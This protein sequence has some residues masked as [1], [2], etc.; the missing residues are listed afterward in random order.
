MRT[1]IL[2]LC[3]VCTLLALCLQ[4]VFFKYSASSIIYRQG[5]EA[6]LNSLENMQNELYVW[7]KSYENN[8]IKIY[9]E[10]D[11]VHDLDSSMTIVSLQPKYRRMAYDMAMTTFDPSQGVDAL[12]L[13]DMNNHLISYYGSAYTPRFNYP[14]DIFVDPGA[15][16][17]DVVSQ[18]VHSDNKVMLV[19]SYYNT[20][21]SED[22]IRF[23]LKIYSNNGTKKIGYMVCDADI[24]SFSRI[25]EKY[26]YSDSQIVWLQPKGDRPVLCYG[27]PLDGQASYYNTAASKIQKNTWTD[28]SGKSMQGNIFFE[29]PQEKYNLV[30]FSLTPP[31]MQKESERVLQ[32]NTLIIALIVI[33]VASVSTLLVTRSLTT[34]LTNIECTLTKIRNGQTEL[35]LT[36]L[37]PDEIGDL[38]QTINDMLDQIN[39]L[40]VQQYASKLLLN[41]AEYKALQAQ[42]NPHFLYN[43]L[44]TMSSV[45]AAQQCHTVS[46]LCQAMA[47]VFRYSIDLKAPLSTIEN[48]IKHIKNYMYVMNVRMQNTIELEIR[49]DRGLLQEKVPRLS[50]QPVVENAIGHGLNNKHGPKKILIDGMMQDDDIVLSV[51]DNGVGMDADKINRYLQ[52]N[53][54]EALEKK[55]SIGLS[56]INA[57]IRLLFG[58]PYGVSVSSVMGEG[59]TVSLRV[60]RVRKEEP[61]HEQDNL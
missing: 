22:I 61:L 42:V 39:K 35:R 54:A 33:I 7:I 25:V 11:F 1:K 3:I 31:Y 44:D 29:I 37:K 23:V 57:R 41:Q 9:N 5:K 21:R 20:S 26:S 18:Y 46:M 12:Y 15:T 10:T 8:M 60:P 45:A 58:E 40:I 50:I 36:G 30:A 13:Y 59:T 16:N 32:Q 6:S 55:D 2:L 27:N 38:G 49:I 51:T 24:N 43:S 14:G 53:S 28:Q 4:S 48:E 52:D 34:P 17:A 47:N 56:N 19:S